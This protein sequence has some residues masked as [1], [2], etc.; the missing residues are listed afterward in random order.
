MKA[1]AKYVFTVLLVLL[2]VAPKGFADDNSSPSDIPAFSQQELDQ[3]LAPIALY[4]DAL[5]SQILMA[6]TYP[7]E[8][9]EAARWSRANPGLKGDA[10]VRA[11]ENRNWD[12]SVKSLVAFP[13]L[14]T[15][16]DEKLEW[17]ERLGD[18]F[19]AQPSQITDSVQQLRQRAYAAGTLRSTDQY[20]VAQRERI[21]VI[22]S[23]RSD[24]VY[25]PY[26]DPY[27][28][29][30][31]WHWSAYPP[32]YWAPWPGYAYRTGVV[33][34][35]WSVGVRIGHG[36][37]FG[38]FDWPRRH[39]RVVNVRPFYYPRVAHT[40]V[41]HH[42][43]W[44]HDPRH[45]RG[46]HY[47]HPQ[48]RQHYVRVNTPQVRREYPHYT[49]PSH[50]VRR[51]WSPHRARGNYDRLDKD[52]HHG[53]DQRSANTM[54]YS[55][56]RSREQVGVAPGQRI[57]PPPVRNHGSSTHGGT[58]V[59]S[60]TPI[61]G[62]RRTQFE[63]R[64]P[65][66]SRTPIVPRA[67]TFQQHSGDQTGGRHHQFGAGMRAPGGDRQS[68][69]STGVPHQIGHSMAP[70]RGQSGQVHAGVRGHSGSRRN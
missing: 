48:V 2:A 49:R 8:I 44:R 37:F 68:N 14:I 40:T 36:F 26:Y 9:V 63:P 18:A 19:L 4:P 32:V 20:R 45:R 69:G 58:S 57:L 12:P 65:L 15:M 35:R 41:V 29:Y 64:T 46:V 28:I 6:A 30:G 38:A 27:V 66:E 61:E 53:R 16:M 42:H 13:Q 60:R 70:L 22:E 23:P 25:I 50:E 17:T 67:Q 52:R 3:M 56:H 31:G 10:A 34:F 1:Y 43:V 51:D 39:I 7:L 47:K 62:R 33:G 21:I 55:G 54:H 24:V 5:L 11:V 59:R